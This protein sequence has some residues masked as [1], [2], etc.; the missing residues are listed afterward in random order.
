MKIRPRSIAAGL[1]AAAA[2]P[3]AAQAADEPLAG[4]IA[5]T[6]AGASTATA[7]GCADDAL[8]TSL[9][10]RLLAKYDESPEVLMQYVWVTQQIHQLDR[11]G[12][13]QWAERYRKTHPR[14]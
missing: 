3:Y 4:S 2:L 1:L 12:A 7:A 5:T 9:Q 11:V 13:A 10:Q 14:C 6:L 8:L